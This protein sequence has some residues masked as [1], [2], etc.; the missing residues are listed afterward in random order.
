MF[1]HSKINCFP[2]DL[3]KGNF[4]KGFVFLIEIQFN[5]V[6]QNSLE[7]AIKFYSNRNTPDLNHYQ[8]VSISKT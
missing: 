6:Y 8:F 7:Q 3:C 4:L 2:K 5:L 1:G